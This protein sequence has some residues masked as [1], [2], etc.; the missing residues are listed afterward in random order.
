MRRKKEGMDARNER[1]LSLLGQEK[2]DARKGCI[3]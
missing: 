2:N 3:G 1:N